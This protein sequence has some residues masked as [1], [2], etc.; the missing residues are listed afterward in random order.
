MQPTPRPLVLRLIAFQLLIFALLAPVLFTALHLVAEFWLM[1]GYR[2]EA[3]RTADQLA[4]SLG[5]AMAQN[6]REGAAVLAQTAV[7]TVAVAGVILRSVEKEVFYHHQTHE[8]VL[9]WLTEPTRFGRTT[10]GLVDLAFSVHPFRDR[11]HLV[12][13]AIGTTLGLSFLLLILLQPWLLSRTLLWPL[14]RLGRSLSET[15][16][17]KLLTASIPVQ[18]KTKEIRVLEVTLS[19]VL[20]ALGAQM[21][22]SRAWNLNL[23]ERVRRRTQ[24]LLKSNHDL[25]ATIDQLL[26]AR[27]SLSRTQPMADLGQLAAGLAHELN[28]PLSAAISAVRTLEHD[29]GVARE[30][31][32]LLAKSETAQALAHATRELWDQLVRP[33][34]QLSWTERKELKQAWL[35]SG[36]S[37]ESPL[38]E[39]L[40]SMGQSG[41]AE[42]VL[43][44]PP[45]GAAEARLGEL[46]HTGVCLRIAG[47]GLERS[48]QIVRRLQ[49]HVLLSQ[50][51]QAPRTVSVELALR[52]A[53]ARAGSDLQGLELETHSPREPRPSVVVEGE[54]WNQVWSTVFRSVGRAI[55]RGRVVCRIE[56]EGTFARIGVWG[57]SEGGTRPFQVDPNWE[58]AISRAFL[59]TEGGRLLVSPDGPHFEI[60]WPEAHAGFDPMVEAVDELGP[61]GDAELLVDPS[62][63]VA[64]RVG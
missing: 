19:N 17:D 56:L 27:T 6:D 2:A 40:V 58:L 49:N 35:D 57:Q 1:Q 24:E 48:A 45:D 25:A 26:L 47:E 50:V 12:A 53:W 18:S 38:F 43:R 10:I 9:F 37:V 4:T 3:Q 59:Q 46:L 62:Q 21:E 15:T 51:L 41:L 5:Y 29:F 13:W 52:E 44:L 63:V 8:E 28:S 22:S 34:P 36:R 14:V 32:Y 60:A 42:Q 64:G 54:G 7:Q 23:E 31:E 11:L 16:L 30:R 20:R 33:R 61:S 39:Y 55:G